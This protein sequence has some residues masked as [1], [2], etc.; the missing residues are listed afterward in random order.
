[1]HTEQRFLDDKGRLRQW[2]SRRSDKLLAV[3]YLATK[4]DFK[5]SYTES[6]VNELLKQWHTFNDW[7]L[8][9][10]ELYEQGFLD[11]N[12]DG[13]NYRIKRLQTSMPDLSL[14][15][16]NIKSDP[17][18]SVE[19]L[20]GEPGKETLRLMG[21]TETNNKPS[22]LKAE[23]QRIREFI[24]STNQRTWNL[25]YRTKTVG[26]TWID[27]ESSK[28][29]KS[30]SIHIMIGDPN[31]RGKGLA[32]ATLQAVIELLEKEGE[33]QHLHSRHLVENTASA[34]LLARVG[35]A[36]DGDEYTDADGLVF[37]NVKRSLRHQ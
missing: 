25:H 22:T 2:P 37:Q 21:S 18:I 13:S 9:R 6:E 36:N 1:M 29:L 12:T 27:L 10:R 33:Y 4:F 3:A 32:Q 8:L 26:A 7:P 11:R 19:W 31:V 35:F 15:N 16:P 28:Y 5:A 23:E 24:T 34:K 14:T 17:A 20:A 30:P